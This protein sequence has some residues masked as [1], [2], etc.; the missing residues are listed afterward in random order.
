MDADACGLRLIVE[1]TNGGPPVVS[2][3]RA[4]EGARDLLRG[5][6]ATGDATLTGF[7][8]ADAIDGTYAHRWVGA[9]GR[10][11]WTLR[12]DLP[13][14]ERIDRVRLVLG[15]DAMSYARATAGRSYAMAWGPW[16]YTLEASEDGRR[17]APVA[18]EPLRPDGT[19]LPLRRRLV[20]IAE[21]R[22]VRALRLRIDGATGAD[23]RPSAEGVP[24]V[25]EMSAYSADDPRPI[26]A[27]PWF[28]SVNANPSGQT[29]LRP[30]R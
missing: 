26:L 19:V 23:G 24:V 21:P 3:V 27:E 4:V 16:R 13:A 18:S 5:G 2:E 10:S 20:T 12:V 6:K 30:G 1:R 14:P 11:K 9:P 17:F 29:H 15:L 28:L 25:R 7:A 8:A 22:Y